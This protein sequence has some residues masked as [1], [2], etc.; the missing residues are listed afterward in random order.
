MVQEI[1]GRIPVVIQCGT[2]TVRE[3]VEL[4]LHAKAIGADAAGVVTPFFFRQNQDALIEYYDTVLKASGGFPVY[5]YNIP[6]FTSN[7]ILPKSVAEIRHRCPNLAGIKYSHPDLIRLSE[8]LAV[9]EGFDALI[10]CDSLIWPAYAL[11]AVGT[12]SGPAAVFP[13]LFRKL[14]ACCERNDTEGARKYQEKIKSND[15][16]LAPFQS[17]PMLKIFLQS[18]GVISETIC[19]VPYRKEDTDRQKVILKTID[20]FKQYSDT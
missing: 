13:E 6:S 15:E 7:D 12:V 5:L 10:G 4:I 16:A 17:V 2:G 11:G 9:A 14:W 19:R 8:Y 20:E 18:R 1:A 3:T